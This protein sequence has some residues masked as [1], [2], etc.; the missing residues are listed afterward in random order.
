MDLLGET[1]HII[2]MAAAVVE[3]QQDF[4]LFTRGCQHSNRRI[5]HD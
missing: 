2:G 5:S 4:D 1:T 3:N